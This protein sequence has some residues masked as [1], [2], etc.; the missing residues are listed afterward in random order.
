MID[1]LPNMSTSE[2]AHTLISQ[3]YILLNLSG[4][5]KYLLLH[6]DDLYATRKNSWQ[7]LG[8]DSKFLAKPSPGIRE[9]E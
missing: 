8:F 1:D 5:V 6:P 9:S 7:I 4:N 2:P 3:R